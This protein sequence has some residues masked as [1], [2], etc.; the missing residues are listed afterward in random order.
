[1]K[2]QAGQVFANLKAALEAHSAT[3][4]NVVKATIFV[5]R[6]DLASEVMAVRKHF[7]GSSKPASSFVEVTAL[8]EPDWLLEVE[9][10][11]AL[12]AN[13]DSA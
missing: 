5:T 12:P 8:N 1:M 7:Y 3:F 6:M 2:E 13:K 9:V 10:I 4:E 11:A